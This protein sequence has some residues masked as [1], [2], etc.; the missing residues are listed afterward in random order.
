M[1][2]LFLFVFSSLAL[3]G[4]TWASPCDSNPCENNGSCVDHAS[5]YGAYNC[6][7]PVNY[8]GQNCEKCAYGYE[9]EQCQT[10]QLLEAVKLNGTAFDP[11]VPRLA[12]FFVAYNHHNATAATALILCGG[13]NY[14]TGIDTAGVC[15]QVTIDELLNNN[16]NTNT[17]GYFTRVSSTSAIARR[18]AGFIKTRDRY[19]IIGGLHGSTV[20]NN[21]YYST[22]LVKWFQ[23]SSGQIWLPVYN[24]VLWTTSNSTAN[25]TW[26]LGGC[27]GS[28]RDGKVYYSLDDGFTWAEDKRLEQLFQ[29]GS[30]FDIHQIHGLFATSM[31]RGVTMLT[32]FGQTTDLSTSSSA[33]GQENYATIVTFN[34]SDE[35][36]IREI[37]GDSTGLEP[38]DSDTCCLPFG[39]TYVSDTVLAFIPIQSHSTTVA[40]TDTVVVKASAQGG[41]LTG[42]NDVMTFSTGYAGG[43]GLPMLAFSLLN[44]LT[45]SSSPFLM[46]FEAPFIGGEYLHNLYTI[47]ITC[48]CSV[49]F[50]CGPS[51]ECVPMSSRSSSSSSS[52][53]TG[54]VQAGS[55]ACASSSPTT[56]SPASG[57]DGSTAVFDP[58]AIDNGGCGNDTCQS[59]SGG[60]YECMTRGDSAHSSSSSSSSVYILLIIVISFLFCG[61]CLTLLL[62]KLFF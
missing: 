50:V 34:A 49:G 9:G 7:C 1:R 21:A 26:M 13:Y 47:Q 23:I 17:S 8:A 2:L 48:N 44:P 5:T 40:V 31:T 43:I 20:L 42:W 25:V 55:T 59:V 54:S 41:G 3:W 35:A 62:C 19:L 4:E 37:P 28:D 56:T 33:P 36:V 24:P 14:D 45:N 46:R 15:Y 11:S 18:Y 32:I 53:S 51:K 29:P 12:G 27:C 10:L 58:C 57:D 60:G 38:Q 52:S 61:T 22:D 16:N 6:F 30:S 39:G